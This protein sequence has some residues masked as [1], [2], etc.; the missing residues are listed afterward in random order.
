MISMLAVYA[1]LDIVCVC[2]CK[3]ERWGGG[4]DR[5][6]KQNFLKVLLSS[7]GIQNNL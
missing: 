3:R 1:I 7:F 2:V 4:R 5:D 6:R